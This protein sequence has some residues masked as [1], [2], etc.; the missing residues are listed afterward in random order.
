MHDPCGITSAQPGYEPAMRATPPTVPPV[1]V[2][3]GA[4]VAVA[5]A[6]TFLGAAACSDE[7]QSKVAD[8]SR[9]AATDVGNAANSASARAQAEAIRANIK[10][11]DRTKTQSTRT[12]AVI[13]DATAKAPGEVR[14]TGVA[15]ADGDGLDDD[16]LVE[17]EFNGAFACI[18]LPAQGTDTTVDDGHCA[19][20]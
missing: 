3:R 1:R 10:T 8:A 20:A 11:D 2:R 18:R 7:T 17:V 5:A 13:Q 14:T 19:T 9:S 15:D 12:M 4:L 16:G 6:L